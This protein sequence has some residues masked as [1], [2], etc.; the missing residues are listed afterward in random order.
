MAG[1]R[2][3]AGQQLARAAENGHCQLCTV[4]A[5]IAV[6]ANNGHA[7]GGRRRSHACEDLRRIVQ[8]FAP[9]RIDH[10]QRPAAHRVHVADIHHDGAVAS[11]PGHRFDEIAH[12]ALDGEQQVAVRVGN[13]GTVVANGHGLTEVFGAVGQGAAQ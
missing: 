4:A 2:G 10:S 13:G 8:A 1:A 11:E 5:R 3:E 12:H 6:A 7:I 9:D